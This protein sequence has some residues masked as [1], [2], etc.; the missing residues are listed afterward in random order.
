[1]ARRP[2]PKRSTARELG[3]GGW[4]LPKPSEVRIFSVANRQ[5]YRAKELLRT[6]ALN[7]RN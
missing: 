2:S 1:M 3:V 6:D 7:S 5:H 4:V